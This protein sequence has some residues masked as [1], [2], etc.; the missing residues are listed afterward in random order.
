MLCRVPKPQT[1]QIAA[2]QG[3]HKTGAGRN[4][5]FC[6]AHFGV[7]PCFDGE[8]PRWV[9]GGRR[10]LGLSTGNIWVFGLGGGRTSDRSKGRR[11]D[12]F[13]WNLKVPACKGRLWQVEPILPFAEANMFSFP[14]L[15]SKGIYHYVAYLH[16]FFFFFFFF[17]RGLSQ[18]G[19]E[20][21]TQPWRPFTIWGLGALFPYVTKGDAGATG[22]R[23][24]FRAR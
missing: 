22:M 15:V 20:G 3:H 19:L 24:S 4:P 10:G 9:G 21:T 5:F 16:F 2:G 8:A 11:F 7:S 1:P 23:V 6:L 13:G 18:M 14:I 17:T 12:P